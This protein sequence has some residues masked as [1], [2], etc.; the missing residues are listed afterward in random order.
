M[1]GSDFH[2]EIIDQGWLPGCP[3][4]E[5]LYSHGHIR[6]TIGGKIVSDETEDYGII[7]TALALLR[8]LATDHTTEIPVAPRLIFHGCAIF[9]MMTCPIGVNWD[10][11]HSSNMIQIGNVTLRKTVDNSD[12]IRFPDL[13]VSVPFEKYK[14]EVVEFA[15]K[16]KSLYANSPKRIEDVTDE[17][18]YRKFWQEFDELFSQ[19]SDMS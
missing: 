4:E 9:P 15:R 12:A 8:T 11:T 14:S 16:A 6:L 7:D 3:A 17:E 1:N 13:A 19:Y 2:I 10:V 5:D 18:E